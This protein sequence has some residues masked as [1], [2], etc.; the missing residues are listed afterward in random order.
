MVLPVLGALVGVLVGQFA[1][2][3]IRRRA[4]AEAR[5]DAAIAAVATMRSA[6]HG[7]QL[8]FPAAWVQA[9]TE[10]EH[11][12]DR[13]ELSKDALKRYLD[14]AAHARSALASLYPWS[15]DL[16]SYW[17]RPFIPEDKFEPLMRL[18]FERR[19]SPL[20]QFDAEGRRVADV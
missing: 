20:A 6:H 18:L 15:P 2:E 8:D 3:W 4:A 11:A 9:T 19:R 17:D 10:E 5:Y 1:P 14:A 16:R 12:R 7:V 13:H